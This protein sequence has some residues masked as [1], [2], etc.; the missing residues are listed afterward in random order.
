MKLAREADNQAPTVEHLLLALLDDESVQAMFADQYVDAAVIRASLQYHLRTTSAEAQPSDTAG[1]APPLQAVMRRALLKSLVSNRREVDVTDVV[2]A[3]LAEDDS[4]AA[5]LLAEQGLTVDEAERESLNRFL[6][7]QERQARRVEEIR[8]RIADENS[9]QVGTSAITS[10][11]SVDTAG[12]A[13]AGGPH[14]YTLR[15]TS[16][17][18]VTATQFKAAVSHDG[19]LD[20]YIEAT[21]FETEFLANRVVALFEA[22]DSDGRLKVELIT[23][24]DG[25]SMPVSGVGGRAGAI[26]DDRTRLG[27]QRSG[28]L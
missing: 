28:T 22:I 21:P 26:F 23:E 1:V 18:G 6:A 5:Q 12:V 10:F 16:E 24:V 15:V 19:R 2:V 14:R 20:L 4:Y 13:T 8:A 17:D 3:I 11:E 7:E 25:R 9:R 27:Q